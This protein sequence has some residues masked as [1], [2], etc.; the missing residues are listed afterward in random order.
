[1]KK[2]KTLDIY[3]IPVSLKFQGESTFKTMIGGVMSLLI[4]ATII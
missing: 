1:M 3:G 2:V 4:Y